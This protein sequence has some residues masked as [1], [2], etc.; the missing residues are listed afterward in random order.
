[1]ENNKRAADLYSANTNIFEMGN[2]FVELAKM[3]G[4]GGEVHEALRE[5][6]RQQVESKDWI[7]DGFRSSEGKFSDLKDTVSLLIQR[8]N[9]LNQKVTS[10]ANNRPISGQPQ[11]PLPPAPA[12]VK[13]PPLPP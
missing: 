7:L 1:M 2:T 8:V 6:Q 11:A 12:A 10:M 3:F 13:P 4:E 5:L 9:N